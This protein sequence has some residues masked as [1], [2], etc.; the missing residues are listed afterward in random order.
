MADEPEEEVRDFAGERRA[1]EGAFGVRTACRVTAGLALG[2][3]AAAVFVTFG[4]S[5]NE[6]GHL[7][8]VVAFVVLGV[9]GAALNLWATISGFGRRGLARLE[10]VLSA[11]VFLGTVV[12]VAGAVLLAVAMAGVAGLPRH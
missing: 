3:Y 4:A 7:P 5:A 10:Y 9:L 6:V 8:V 1:S 11:V 12:V 2:A